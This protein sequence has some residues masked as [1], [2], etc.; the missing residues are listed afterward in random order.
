MN[1][2]PPSESGGEFV[3]IDD[4]ADAAPN[5]DLAQGSDV[6]DV[7][8]LERQLTGESLDAMLRDYLDDDRDIPALPPPLPSRSGRR[9]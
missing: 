3:L 8:D 7:D 9:R 6:H 5:A 1:D 2:A 4:V